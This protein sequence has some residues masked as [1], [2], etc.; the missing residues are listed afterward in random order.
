M[1]RASVELLSMT[2]AERPK[3]VKS[4]ASME[5]LEGSSEKSLTNDSQESVPGQSDAKRAK[6]SITL[7]EKENAMLPD[8]KPAPGNANYTNIHDFRYMIV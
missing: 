7:E 5:S 2:D 4:E 3:G 1:I 8:L 6:R